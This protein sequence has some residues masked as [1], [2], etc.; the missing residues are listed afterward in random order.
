LQ[1]LVQIVNRDVYKD[2][3]HKTQGQDG[4]GHPGQSPD[5]ILF[6]PE[7]ENNHAQI[8]IASAIVVQTAKTV[9]RL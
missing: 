1:F 6:V 4:K 8:L 5:R 3:Q 2:M 9:N 7:G